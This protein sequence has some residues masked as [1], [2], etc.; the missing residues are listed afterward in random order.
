MYPGLDLADGLVANLFFQNIGL[1][2]DLV[3]KNQARNF[4]NYA[5]KRER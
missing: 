1:G 2:T 5:K 4:K 3:Q